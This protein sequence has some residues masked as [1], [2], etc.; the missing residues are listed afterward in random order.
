MKK[1]LAAVKHFFIGMLAI[2][3]PSVAKSFFPSMFV[4][5]MPNGHQMFLLRDITHKN[6]W[7]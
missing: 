2:E 4:G 3:T 6:I 1:H 5:E 7:Q